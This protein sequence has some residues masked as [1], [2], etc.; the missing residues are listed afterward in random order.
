MKKCIAVLTILLTAGSQPGWSEMLGLLN[1]LKADGS[2]EVAGQQ[3]QN[4]FDVG[5]A[6][7]ANDHRGATVS[8]VRIGLSAD[9]A[10]GVR[11][12]LEA[13]RNS[14]SGA[15]IVQFG[16]GAST[17]TTEQNS[18]A[19][20]N[21]FIEVRDFLKFFDSLRLGRQYLGRPGD[22]LVYF[23]NYNDDAMTLSALDSLSVSKK[24]GRIHLWAVTGKARED[25]LIAAPDFASATG[26][27]NV[28]WLVLTS[29]ELIPSSLKIP[30][31]L[32]L[33]QGTNSQTASSSDDINLQVIDLRAGVNLADDAVK[34]G[35]EYA[36][37]GGKRHFA[38]PASDVKYKGS[39]LL[40]SAA[41]DNK[42]YEWGVHAR[43][44]NASGDD[45]TT[46]NSDDKAFHNFSELGVGCSDY[47]FG[48]ILSYSNL[49][50]ASKGLTAGQNAGLD[51]GRTSATIGGNGLNVFNVGADYVFPFWN[52][53]FQGV[54]DY[55]IV[56]VNKVATGGDKSVGNEIDLSVSYRYSK[57]VKASLGYAILDPGDGLVN[58]FGPALP[59]RNSDSVTKLYTKL[60][61]RFGT[62]S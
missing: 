52:K 58:S 30:L 7:T 14:N 41:Y 49:F 36:M 48:E 38:A 50:V 25:D 31:E 55:Y 19:F 6:G 35:F 20:Q 15:G 33:Y 10:E 4:E 44:A 27:I 18:I 8:R 45:Q 43:F 5:T 42:D 3:A 54:L 29:S 62:G 59:G 9:L 2:L 17:I 46:A 26:D 23:G 21:A 40:L 13:V 57:G 39:A 12:R 16:D 56:S 61:I 32:G 22:N 60:S 28:N 11:G 1:N 51:S 53:A 34:L 24:W 47:R 37:N